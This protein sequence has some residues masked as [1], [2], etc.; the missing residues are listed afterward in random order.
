M[1]QWA[2]IQTYFFFSDIRIFVKLVLLCRAKSITGLEVRVAFA[3]FTIS[4]NT[5]V[6]NID[7]NIEQ[8]KYI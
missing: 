2:K 8:T 4:L 3:L 7:R 6:N 5:V 1:Q